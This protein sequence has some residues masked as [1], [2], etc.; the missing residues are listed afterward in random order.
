[1]SFTLRPRFLPDR[2]VPKEWGRKGFL[3]VRMIRSGLRVP[4][5]AAFGSTQVAEWVKTRSRAMP[6][7]WP[8]SVET[9][10]ELL[11]GGEKWPLILR[12]SP[13]MGSH[14]VGIL[15]SVRVED[16]TP[17][18]LWDAFLQLT[19]PLL[20]S[21]LPGPMPAI[22]IQPVLVGEQTGTSNKPLPPS[23]PGHEV[24]QA[25]RRMRTALKSDVELD[26]LWDGEQLWWVEARSDAPTT[27][28]GGI[29]IWPA[30]QSW[31]RR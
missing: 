18:A 17:A 6:E 3:L 31:L 14:S 9:L 24:E 15:K 23:V 22:L 16:P 20:E 7:H 25:V 4:P 26:W 13:A 5:T 12:P 28:L 29:G 10:T 11:T 19:A 27:S 1:M 8:N 2:E 21:E 30:L